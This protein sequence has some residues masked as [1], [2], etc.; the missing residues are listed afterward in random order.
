[1]IHP[2]DFIQG[3][4]VSMCERFTVKN[5][6]PLLSVL[7][8]VGTVMVFA[9]PCPR[10][11]G[12]RPAG[13]S[14]IGQ[15]YGYDMYDQAMPLVW[16]RV[17]AYVNYSLVGSAATGSNGMYVMFLPTGVITVSVESQGFKTKSTN[18]AISDG[19]S[20]VMNF[21][22][23]R[24]EIPIPEFKANYLPIVSVSLLATALILIKRKRH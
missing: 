14:L 24:S 1:M 21:Y 19:G 8:L 3:A 6:I 10:V 18:V 7:L 2:Q 22:L 4:R 16:A 23:E 15:V 13:G 17:V 20:A 11:E 5:S 12:V 9:S